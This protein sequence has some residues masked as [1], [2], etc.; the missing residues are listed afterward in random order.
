MTKPTK[1]NT[2]AIQPDITL[3]DDDQKPMTTTELY[4]ALGTIQDEL[5]RVEI[6]R[7]ALKNENAT[8]KTEVERLRAMPATGRSGWIVKTPYAGFNG[9]TA[10]VVFR[11]G[12][13][14]IPDNADG[15][16]LAHELEAEFGYAVSFVT[17]YLAP[18]EPTSVQT[19]KSLVDALMMPARR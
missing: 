4:E 12:T 18:E 9:V 15:A 7:D 17:D 1:T 13:A 2:A 10:G 11:N 6:E 5:D 16:R 8:L 3:P 14:L 19:G